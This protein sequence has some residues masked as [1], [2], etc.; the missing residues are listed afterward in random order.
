MRKE[1]EIT[2]QP[3]ITSCCGEVMKNAE[4]ELVDAAPVSTT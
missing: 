4:A 1:A 3:V 2:F